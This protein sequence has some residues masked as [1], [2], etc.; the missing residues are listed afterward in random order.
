MWFS[1]FWNPCAGGKGALLFLSDMVGEDPAEDKF[2]VLPKGDSEGLWLMFS[3][4]VDEWRLEKVSGDSDGTLE[5]MDSEV[6]G[7]RFS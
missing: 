2:S 1:P 3:G 4:A 7:K 6:A 5:K